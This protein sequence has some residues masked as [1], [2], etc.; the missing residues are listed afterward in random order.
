MVIRIRM[1][2]VIR[3]RML[4]RMRMVI[5][6]KT[7]KR[8]RM[9]IVMKM[10]IM[11]KMVTYSH[12]ESFIESGVPHL[13]LFLMLSRIPLNRLVARENVLTALFGNEFLSK[14]LM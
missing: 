4:I 7:R 9:K 6:K 13:R 1:T 12:L 5:R 14:F 8:I 10:V 11:V 3:M 2:L